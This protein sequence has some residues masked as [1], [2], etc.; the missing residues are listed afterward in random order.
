MPAERSAQHEEWTLRRAAVIGA[1]AMGTAV[2]AILGSVIPVVNVC[3]E[4]GRAAQLFRDGATV[5][6]LINAHARPI[7]VGRIS[8]LATIGGISAVF[9]ATKTTAIPAV[10]AELRPIL[11]SLGDQPGAPYVISFQNGIDPG[12]QLIDLLGCTRM[13][14]MVL[15]LGAT[16]DA[17]G[18]AR[19]SMNNPP[20]AIGCIDAGNIPASRETARVLTGAGFPTEHRED[21]E[22][23][24]WMKS[25][26]NA[27]ANPVAALVN[28]SVGEVLSSP[29]RLIL[30]RLLH[31][32]VAVAAADG[33][34]LGGDYVA[35]ALTLL[36][37]G[38]HHVPSMVEDIRAGRETEI[39][40]LNRQIIEHARKRGVAT[41]THE[42]IDALIETFDWRI[43]HGSK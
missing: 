8:D 9:V 18:A 2:C 35:R 34:D 23:C 22:R 36:E 42:V 11:P 43:Y 29:S 13:L 39:G 17:S 6:G 19:V 10:A 1:G 25:V 26:V 27:A 21:I 3:I 15:N 14:R 38:A 24:V 32:G 5:A 31:E 30:E 40:Q 7:V 4:A 37:D 16:L 33:L 28:A 41:P 12:R 20:H